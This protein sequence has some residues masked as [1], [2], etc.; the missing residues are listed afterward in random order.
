MTRR[1]H[2]GVFVPPPLLYGIPLMVA[3][4]LDAARPWPIAEGQLMILTMSGAV[5]IAAGIAIGVASVY[6]FRNANT[7]IL[8]AGRPTTAIVET[9]PYRF[10]RNPMYVAM[11][12]AY[13]GL[14]LVLNNLWALVL[15]PLVVGVVDRWVIGREE[16][17]LTAKFG[18]PY[19]D[20]CARVR[21]WL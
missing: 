4:M 16:R 8:P 2:A 20:Y 9:G 15:L 11:C 6:S 3:A 13:I 5:I 10:T 1:D 17:Y 19:R 7:T 21:R 14:S 18:D 12:C